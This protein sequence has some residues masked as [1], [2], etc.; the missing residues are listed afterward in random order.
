MERRL[1]PFI[2]RRRTA[3]EY[4]PPVPVLMPMTIIDI[5]GLA[6]MS[7]GEKMYNSSDLVMG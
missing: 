2:I 1:S 6:D 5:L 4:A 3:A 7:P